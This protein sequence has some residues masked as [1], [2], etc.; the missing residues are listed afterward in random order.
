MKNVKKF[1]NMN[2]NVLKD[3]G[4]LE[5]IAEMKKSNNPQTQSN[6][7]DKMVVAQYLA[8]VSL[9]P[10][11]KTEMSMMGK[12]S[13]P[14]DTKIRFH[15]IESGKGEKYFLAFTSFQEMAKWRENANVPSIVVTFNDYA[16]LLAKA[17][18]DAEIAG[19]VIDPFG[20]NMVFT[21]SQ[22]L[23]IKKIKDRHDSNVN[24]INEGEEVYIGEPMKYPTEMVEAIK[25]YLQEQ[26]IINKAYLQLMCRGEDESYVIVLDYEGD[27]RG[28]M[29]KVAEVAR[30]Y[31]SDKPVDLI[32]VGTDL[33][34]KI[35]EKVTPFFER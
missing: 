28:I 8:P 29:E 31:M 23:E 34:K 2:P 5:A 4:L 32:G 10:E 33:G 35:A 17:E 30:P 25:A 27:N 16:N 22:A 20:A 24:R 13:L 12:V 26:Y 1:P 19:F 14:P 6:M 21:K 7:L 18:E 15:M 11:P 9:T 3:N